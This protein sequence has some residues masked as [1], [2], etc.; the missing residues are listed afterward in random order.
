[1]R[2]TKRTPLLAAAVIVGAL[3]LASAQTSIDRAFSRFWAAAGPADAAQLVE[4]ILRAG[5]TFDDA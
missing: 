3:R 1:M 5:A 2:V 4:P